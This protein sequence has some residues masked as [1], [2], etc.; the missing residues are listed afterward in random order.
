M[1]KMTTIKADVARNG[2]VAKATPAGNAMQRRS[3]GQY[4]ETVEAEFALYEPEIRE[5]ASQSQTRN[6]RRIL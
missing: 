4:L 6:R 3:E 5:L 1:M 2:D